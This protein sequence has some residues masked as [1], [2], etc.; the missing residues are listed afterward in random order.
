MHGFMIVFGVFHIL[1]SLCPDVDCFECSLF[2][3]I[4][5][6]VFVRLFIACINYLMANFLLVPI[7]MC[8]SLLDIVSLCASGAEVR[9]KHQLVCGFVYFKQGGWSG[10]TLTH[11]TQ[12]NRGY[13]HNLKFSLIAF[14]SCLT[15]GGRL[16]PRLTDMPAEKTTVTNSTSQGRSSHLGRTCTED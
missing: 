9:T 6:Q 11:A 10:E 14:V 7:I 2:V 15:I 1:C 8:D 4:A 3:H 16:T 12:E 5:M 13:I